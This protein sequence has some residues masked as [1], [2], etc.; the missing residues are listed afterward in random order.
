MHRALDES[1]EP[2]QAL[3]GLVGI[4]PRVLTSGP[5]PDAWSGRSGLAKWVRAYGDHLSFV[6]SGGLK[7]E[8]IPEMLAMVK[9]QEYHFGSAARTDGA[10]DGAKVRLLRTAL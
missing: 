7:L 3:A 1:V 10:V 9:A 2:E 5:A 4:A 8:Q 6:V